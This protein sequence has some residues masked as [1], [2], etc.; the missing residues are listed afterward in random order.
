MLTVASLIL[1]GQIQRQV[2]LDRGALQ[3]LGAQRNPAAQVRDALVDVEQP[4]TV[5]GIRGADAQIGDAGK[6]RSSK[7]PPVVFHQYLHGVFQPAQTN[8]DVAV[9][10]VFGHIYQE[11]AHRREQEYAAFLSHFARSEE[12]TS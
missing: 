5:L 8:A 2:N 12:H 10:S 6:S 7:T 4:K 9:S 1:C 3:R 11:L